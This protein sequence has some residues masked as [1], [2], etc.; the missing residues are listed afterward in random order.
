MRWRKLRNR[1]KI[2]TISFIMKQ[3]FIFILIFFLFSCQNQKQGP[4]VNQF[5]D[6]WHKAAAMAN[7]DKFFLKLDT[8]AVYLGTQWDEHW[9][10]QEFATFAKPFFDRGRA[11]D[12]K[13]Y[14][15]NYQYSKDKSLI[16]F[17]ESL[18]TWMG[19][20]RGSGVI[21]NYGDSLRL[22]QYNLAVTI[23]NELVHDFVELVK[24]DSINSF[25]L[26]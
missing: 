18:K 24:Q 14:K 22:V 16:W 3:S 26:K 13:P 25:L 8:D 6:D 19:I 4:D 10:K 12:F 2:G 15:R 5:M 11:W 1:N 21:R 7:F 20:C 23:S 9:T 17:D